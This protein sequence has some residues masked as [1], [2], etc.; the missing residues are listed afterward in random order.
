MKLGR[1]FGHIWSVLIFI[2][3]FLASMRDSPEGK[4]FVGPDF[5]FW[6]LGMGPKLVP[7]QNFEKFQK[8]KFFFCELCHFEPEKAIK[9]LD[10]FFH[11]T[12]TTLGGQA[13]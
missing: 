3:A 11:H 7:D 2:F 9:K 6:A 1:T 12:T 4:F 5:H 8:K 13:I 10:L